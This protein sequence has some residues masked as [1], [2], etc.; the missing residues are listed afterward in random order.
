MVYYSH[1]PVAT[2]PF[3]HCF[4]VHKGRQEREGEGARKKGER[5]EGEGRS[6]GDKE[7]GMGKREG[8]FSKG[9]RETMRKVRETR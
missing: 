2:P 5:G 3:L 1:S 6:K 8:R 4:A 7:K 9:G